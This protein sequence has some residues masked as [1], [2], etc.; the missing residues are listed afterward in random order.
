VLVLEKQ[1]SQPFSIDLDIEVDLAEA[2]DTDQLTDTVDYGSV[3]VATA[4]LVETESHE[5]LERV[6][7][8]IAQQIL[9]IERVRAVDVTVT[10]LRPP[11]PVD[12]DTVSVTVRRP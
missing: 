2:A 10:K 12:V 7:G 9:N 1:Q 5:L 4:R 6:A 8:R 3:A 11:I